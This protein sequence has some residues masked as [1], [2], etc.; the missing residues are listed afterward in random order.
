MVRSHMIQKL[1]VQIVDMVAYNAATGDELWRRSG[2]RHSWGT[3]II[4]KIV[5][6]LF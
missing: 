4:T 3:G 2:L 5:N 6:W 1:I